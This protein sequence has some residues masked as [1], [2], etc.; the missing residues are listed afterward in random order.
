MR[1]WKIVRPLDGSSEQKTLI[2]SD[3]DIIKE[4]FPSW[5][6]QMHKIGKANKICIKRCI[7]DWVIVNWAEKINKK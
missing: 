3:D 5:S 4:Y 1:Y 7:R 6:E 2:Y